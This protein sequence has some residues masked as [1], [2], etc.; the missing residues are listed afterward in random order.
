MNLPIEIH[1]SVFLNRIGELSNFVSFW[2]AYGFF[3]DQWW[4]YG[5]RMSRNIY[6]IRTEGVKQPEIDPRVYDYLADNDG[7]NF[8][9]F[10]KLQRKND[11][12]NQ[13]E[14]KHLL[15]VSSIELV[16]WIFLFVSSVQYNKINKIEKNP[17]QTGFENGMN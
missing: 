7:Q 2:Y 5:F 8:S 13:D 12:E 1:Q 6:E 3:G 15:A 16:I 4:Q 14:S 17:E 9:E 11:Q 10:L